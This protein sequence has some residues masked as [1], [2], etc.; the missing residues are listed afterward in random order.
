MNDALDGVRMAGEALLSLVLNPFTY[1]GLILALLVFRRQTTME[2]KLFY[3]R[4]HNMAGEFLRALGWGWAAGIAVSLATLGIGLVLTFE[5]LIWLWSASLLLMLIRFRYACMAYA[6]GLVALLQLAVKPF[7]AVLETQG[8]EGITQSLLDIHLPSLFALVALLHLA[9]AVLVR[10][11]LVRMATPLYVAGKRGKVIGA[12]ELKG[13]WAVPLF[14]VVPAMGAE[15]AVSGLPLLTWFGGDVWN[16][17][18]MLLAFPVMI[19]TSHKVVASSPEWRAKRTAG[20]ALLFAVVIGGLAAGAQ[21][22]SYVAIAAAVASF[23]LHEGFIVWAERREKHLSPLFVQDGSGLKVLAVQPGSPAAEMGIVRG[24][25]VLKAN[26]V[27]VSTRDELHA[28][29]RMNSAFCRLEVLNTDGHNRFAQRPL[30]DGEHH[31]LGLVLCPADDVVHYTEWRATTL[32]SL[33]D[34][35]RKTTGRSSASH[36]A[37]P[38]GTDSTQEYGSGI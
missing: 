4:L 15:G 35:H 2:R 18:W 29:L 7:P 28:A 37:A 11:N 33:F 21:L 9:E 36:A 6:A 16:A 19:G 3:V 14:L 17:G 30:Y 20:M 13:F 5:T 38:L 1:I 24:E 12:Y 31:Q 26:G 25:V 8:L 10:L 23:G 32:L 34:T 27:A 22:W